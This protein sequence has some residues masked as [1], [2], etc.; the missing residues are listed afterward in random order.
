MEDIKGRKAFD[1]PTKRQEELKNKILEETITDGAAEPNQKSD[2][3]KSLIVK[4]Q[5]EIV[6][7]KKDIK[8]R[9]VTTSI[10]V[11]PEVIK[12]FEIMAAERKLESIRA[13]QNN[14]SETKTKLMREALLEYLA[15]R[16]K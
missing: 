13:G 9:M 1:L 11:E 2:I 12:K 4:R 15:K 16:S 7:A 10:V 3:E 5:K 6:A 8:P 14:G